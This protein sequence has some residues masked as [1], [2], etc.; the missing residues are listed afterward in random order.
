MEKLNRYNHEMLHDG[1]AMKVRDPKEALW[2]TP[3]VEKS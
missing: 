2:K 1:E 3:D